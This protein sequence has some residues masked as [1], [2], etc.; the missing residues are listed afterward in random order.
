M[1]TALLKQVRESLTPKLTLEQLSEDVNISVSQLSRFESGDRRPRV[2]ELERIA[3][4]LGVDPWIFLD[5]Q[6]P[7]QT[8]SEA[9]APDA[10]PASEVRLAL[11]DLA[12]RIGMPDNAASELADLFL[13]EMT[14]PQSP[15][16]DQRTSELRVAF[17]RIVRRF[18][19]KSAG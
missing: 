7:A 1:R 11:E 17:D 6:P 9:A 10:V 15:V 2:D 4:R 19:P 12:R 5:K 3:E 8:A 14:E 16:L 13:E 18:S